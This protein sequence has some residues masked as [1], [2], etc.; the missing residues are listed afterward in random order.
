MRQTRFRS[1]CLVGLFTFAMTMIFVPGPGGRAAAASDCENGTV[2]SYLGTTC[3]LEPA[4]YRWTSYSCTS[5][6]SSICA[7]LGNN[8]SEINI[9]RDPRGPRTLLV[10]GTD[11][12]NVT[13]GQSVDIVIR[14]EVSG[15]TGNLTW[16]HF[17]GRRG[18]TGDGS[19]ENITT[20]Y[21]GEN[22]ISGAGVSRILCT[23]GSPE[24]NCNQQEKIAPYMKAA[25]KFR[26]ASAD[27]PYPFSIEVKMNGG[28][29]GT[30]S[31]HSLGLHIADTGGGGGGGRARRRPF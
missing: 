12:W 2:A 3:T 23:A 29:S 15:A 21:C 24:E 25:A 6:P 18:Q 8:G 19:E 5:T 26:V 22:C 17:R 7:R 14:G 28:T 10:G 30:A 20:V 13:A 16:P 4:T 1:F 11:R 9:R 27:H 31:L